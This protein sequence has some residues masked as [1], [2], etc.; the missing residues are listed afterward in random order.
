MPDLLAITNSGPLIALAGVQC[1]DLLPQLYRRV[2]APRAVLEE[3]MAGRISLHVIPFCIIYPGSNSSKHQSRW[4][5]L[6]LCLDVVKPR[7]LRLP[8]TIHRRSC[9]STIDRLAEQ[10]KPLGWPPQGQ[11]AS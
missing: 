9:Y 11:P 6:P 5:H 7:P 1:L 3:I 4:T 2:A 10:P 8:D